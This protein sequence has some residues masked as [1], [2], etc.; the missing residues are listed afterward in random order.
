MPPLFWWYMRGGFLLHNGIAGG[1]EHSACSSGP[2]LSVVRGRR[3]E[4]R[5]LVAGQENELGAPNPKNRLRDRLSRGGERRRASTFRVLAF[6]VSP[7]TAGN[8]SK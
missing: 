5:C 4:Y 1:P 2:Q 6:P 8:R 3:A 7:P